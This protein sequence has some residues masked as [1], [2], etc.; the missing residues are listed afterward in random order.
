[1]VSLVVVIQATFFKFNQGKSIKKKTLEF[2]VVLGAKE[3]NADLG[4]FFVV[5]VDLY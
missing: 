4:L 5:L 1:M 2:Y 3:Q